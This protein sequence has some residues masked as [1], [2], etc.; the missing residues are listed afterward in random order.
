MAQVFGSGMA[1]DCMLSLKPVIEPPLRS[2]NAAPSVIEYGPAASKAAILLPENE[3]GSV[4]A[5]PETL[6]SN[7]PG[8]LSGFAPWR[9]AASA[10]KRSVE[11]GV[12]RFWLKVSDAELLM[13][14]TG[15]TK[16]VSRRQ[17]RDRERGRAVVDDVGRGQLKLVDGAERALRQR[18]L[19]ERRADRLIDQ[20]EVV[21]AARQVA[22]QLPVEAREGCSGRVDGQ[23]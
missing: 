12:P 8:V 14:W 7:V 13:A 3:S 1:V 21:G 23:L 16:S 5:W 2:I 22:A 20:Q 6:S 19:D 18:D 4:S 15:P 10:Q 9:F 11:S 17:Q